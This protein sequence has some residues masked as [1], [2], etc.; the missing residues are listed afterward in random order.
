MNYLRLDLKICEGCGVLWLRRT[1]ADG[2]YCTTCTTRLA[3]FPAVRAIHRGGRPRLARTAGCCA[4][5]RQT[6]GTQ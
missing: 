2:V 5:R 3:S 1:V 4:N 6:A